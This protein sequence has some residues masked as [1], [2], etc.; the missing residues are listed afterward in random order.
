MQTGPILI[1]SAQ[2]TRREQLST[3]LVRAGYRVLTTA[4]SRHALET[5]AQQKLQLVLLDLSLAD[6]DPAAF[7]RELRQER[8]VPI[9]IVGQQSNALDRVAA[10]LLC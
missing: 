7:C 6:T 3:S 4:Q 5:A 1:V 10:P 8:F 9:L 2:Q